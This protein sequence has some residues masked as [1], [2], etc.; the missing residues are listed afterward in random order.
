MPLDSF[1]GGT[2][3]E[4]LYPHDIM[5]SQFSKSEW[6]SSNPVCAALNTELVYTFRPVEDLLSEILRIHATNVFYGSIADI[7]SSCYFSLWSRLWPVSNHHVSNSIRT[8]PDRSRPDRASTDERF[9]ENARGGRF[10]RFQPKKTK[11]SPV[12]DRS[13]RTQRGG[14]TLTQIERRGESS[15]EGYCRSIPNGSRQN[16][17]RTGSSDE[18]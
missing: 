10:L 8:N 2:V 7:P 4:I 13:S 6:T 9:E 3:V 5:N 14:A 1:Y 18:I 12:P 17:S 16:V 11:A 15:L